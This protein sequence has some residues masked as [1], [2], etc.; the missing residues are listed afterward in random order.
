MTDLKPY[1]R[2]DRT[3]SRK[4]IRQI[5]DSINKFDYSQS[6]RC[7]EY[8][9]AVKPAVCGNLPLRLFISACLKEEW[10]GAGFALDVS[11]LFQHL[12]LISREC[13]AAMAVTKY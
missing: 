13:V 11:V 6:A 2:N 8:S 3:H 7:R 12:T 4:Q 1:E 9:H 5:A 10:L